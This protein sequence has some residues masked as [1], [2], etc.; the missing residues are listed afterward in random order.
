MSYAILKLGQTA[1]SSA[2]DRVEHSSQFG[3]QTTIRNDNSGNA[4]YQK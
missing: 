1:E 4:E 2:L 3:L